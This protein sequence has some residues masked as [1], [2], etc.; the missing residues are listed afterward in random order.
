MNITDVISSVSSCV[1]SFQMIIDPKGEQESWEYIL[2][3]CC[4]ETSG[5]K[6]NC[7]DSG[8]MTTVFGIGDTWNWKLHKNVESGWPVHDDTMKYFEILFS[9]QRY[10]AQGH[11][12]CIVSSGDIWSGSNRLCSVM[13]LPM[14]PGESSSL[15]SPIFRQFVINYCVC[16]QRVSDIQKNL[17]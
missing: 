14:S 1:N 8:V 3:L 12:Y 6:N 15:Q 11:R 13:T 5:E 16:D 7:V 17:V 10:V 9:Q 2:R 4:R